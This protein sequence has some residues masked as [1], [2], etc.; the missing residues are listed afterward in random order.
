[1]ILYRGG[2]IGKYYCK[3]HE[4]EMEEGEPLALERHELLTYGELKTNEN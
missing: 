1:M 3:E 4:H 2:F